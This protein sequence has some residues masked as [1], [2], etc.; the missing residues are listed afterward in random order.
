MKKLFLYVFLGLLLSGCSEQ[1]QLDECI[2]GDCNNGYGTFKWTF[3]DKYVG[4]F[5]DNER[6]GQ[7]THTWVSGEF[8]GDKYVGEYKDG[9]PYGQGTWTYEDGRIEKGILKKDKLIK[10]ATVSKMMP[11]NKSFDF[12][13]YN[14]CKER[15]DETFC[16]QKCSIHTSI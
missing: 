12:I 13:C 11:M 8:V 4:G 9:Q 14:T 7:G 15:N 6:H 1:N 2:K 16:R 5:K 10:F 3:G